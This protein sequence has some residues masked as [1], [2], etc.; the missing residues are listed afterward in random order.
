MTAAAQ[1]DAFIRNALA[2]ILDL[3]EIYPDDQLL[4]LGLDS[5]AA[6]RLVARVRDHTGHELPLRVVFA[7]HTVAELTEALTQALAQTA[8][9]G[10]ADD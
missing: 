9:V 1:V 7:F 8:P 3:D 6:A 10:H 4:D 2:E 5:L